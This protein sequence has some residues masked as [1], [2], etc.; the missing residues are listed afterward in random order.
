M[1]SLGLAFLAGCLT[2]RNLAPSKSP[3]FRK[4]LQCAS[5]GTFFKKFVRAGFGEVDGVYVDEFG[6]LSAPE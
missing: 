6:D 4:L 1:W 2:Y 3:H 5:R